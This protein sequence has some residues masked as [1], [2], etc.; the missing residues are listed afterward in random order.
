MRLVINAVRGFPSLGE[1]LLHFSAITLD[2]GSSIG[3]GSGMGTY[4]TIFASALTDDQVV[5]TSLGLVYLSL[6]VQRHS[7]LLQSFSTQMIDWNKGL[8]WED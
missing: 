5:D 3:S 2:G 1:V 7:A 8:F 6:Y 4:D